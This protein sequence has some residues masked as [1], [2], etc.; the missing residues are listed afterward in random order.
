MWTTTPS[1]LNRKTSTTSRAPSARSA[2]ISQ[3]QLVRLLFQVIHARHSFTQV[4]ETSTASTSPETSAS[5]PSSW[6]SVSQPF[7]LFLETTPST[8]PLHRPK[9]CQRTNFFIRRQ[10]RFPRLPRRLRLLQAR[11]PTSHQPRRRQSQP[12]HRPAVRLP[13]RHP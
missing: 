9:I 5:T 8:K 4:S 12:R 10:T 3:L 7:L 1:T 2:P 13:D 6:E 11:I